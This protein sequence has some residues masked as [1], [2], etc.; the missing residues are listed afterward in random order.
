MQDA[1]AEVEPEVAP[2]QLAEN[3][4]GEEDRKDQKRVWR[5]RT[6]PTSLIKF[7]A[8][9]KG[10]GQPEANLK[11][12]RERNES[13]E[14]RCGLGCMV[15][16][17]CQRLNNIYCFMIFYCL[18][19]TSQGI[20]FGLID[21]SIDTFQKAYHLSNVE[22]LLLSLTYDISSCLIVVFISYY[23][24][25]GNIPR[26]ITFSS[27]LVG[28][29][30]L[31]FAFPYFS[32]GNYQSSINIEDICQEMKTSK[33]CK[34]S[35][36]FSTKYIASFIL[37]QTVQGIAGM[38]L[39]VLGVVFIGNSVATHS[40]GIYIGLIE[41][42]VVLGYSLSYM[43]VALLIKD[44]ENSTFAFSGED[45]DGDQRWMQKWWI[46][47]GLVSLIAWSTL[48]PL[49]CFPHS[50]RGTAK[51]KAEKRKQPNPFKLKIKDQEFG[52]SLKDLFS[53]I[54]VLL[55]SP[56]F[57]CLALTKASESLVYIGASE[58]LPIYI[59]NQFIL[60]HST[61]TKIAGFVLLLGGALGQLLGGCTQS[62]TFNY[63]K[64]YYNCS[65]IQEGLTTSDDQG[66][67]IDARPG[68]CDTK[69]Y[70]LPLFVAF[71]FST[72][73]FSIFSRI[74]ST[75]TILRI[76]PDNQRYLALGL[77][78]VILRIFGTI[79]GP[80]LFRMAGDTSCIFRVTEYCGNKG[81]C[82]I[83][84][85]LKMAYLMVGI[86]S[87]CKLITIFFTA[88]AFCLYKCL[89]EENSDTLHIPVK[90]LKV[91]RK[92]KN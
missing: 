30:S 84:N 62:K 2:A 85:K 38:P 71:I 15:I 16:P 40:A 33:I 34:K 78:Y 75:L 41:S 43:I 61:A 90:N 24:G 47:F 36:S 83:Y 48:I 49:S 77:T 67:F 57:I 60:T 3:A 37:G 12:N 55:K 56:L 46:Y 65:C 20:V 64:A 86:C 10:R 17:C 14:G 51:I 50:I 68:T 69:C 26:W 58:F 89:S 4:Q 32:D 29:G 81:N 6:V 82:W 74:P 23:G 7:H 45:T 54:W 21:L 25:K 19:V 72:I 1:L 42:S 66:D 27:F 22:N 87:I 35:S 31:L 88:I 8:F 11:K 28:F 52:T 44:T 73:L 59:E 92:G 9:Q 63:H 39:Y 79:P 53:T 18:L 13:L 80:I 5:I 70:K 91:K 76:V